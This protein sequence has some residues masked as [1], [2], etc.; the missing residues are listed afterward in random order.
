MVNTE[1][2]NER[3]VPLE[4]FVAWLIEQQHTNQ[5]SDARMAE[6]I[7][8]GAST[9]TMVRTRQRRVGR[10]VMDGAFRRYP[11]LQIL[12]AQSLGKESVNR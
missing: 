10:N 2:V 6:E 1:V 3:L 8:C 4:P 5:W 7:G 9:W 12:Y 11:E